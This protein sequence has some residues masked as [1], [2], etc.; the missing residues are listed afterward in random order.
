MSK[1][2]AQ[3]NTAPRFAPY[4]RGE[5]GQYKNVGLLTA[6]ALVIVFFGMPLAFIAALNLGIDSENVFVGIW[7]IT[8]IYVFWLESKV[9]PKVKVGAPHIAALALFLIGVPGILVSSPRNV[10]QISLLLAY[11]F[12]LIARMAIMFIFIP[13]CLTES[14]TSPALIIVRTLLYSSAFVSALTS[15]YFASL[16]FTIFNSIRG[17]P[18]NWLHPNLIS[19]LGSLCIMMTVIDPKLKMP[20]RIFFGSV[21]FYTMLMAQGRTA[22]FS[23]IIV[24]FLIF[25]LELLHDPKK[26][27]PKAALW[28]T[29]L[30]IVLSLATPLILNIPAVQNIQK[31]NEASD[32]LAGR[33]NY[34]AAALDAWRESQIFGYGFRSGV[35]DNFYAVMLLQT[36]IVGLMIYLAFFFMCAIRGYTLFKSRNPQ[37]KLL[38]KTIIILALSFV[39]RSFTEGATILQLTDLPANAFCLAVGLS[40]MIDPKSNKWAD[41]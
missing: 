10:V 37:T 27:A 3:P 14:R 21:G 29:L 5:L 39:I 22:I 41:S 15:I 17:A 32:P 23:T 35:L 19:L 20:S 36:G 26:Y 30:A 40:F 25:M 7:A 31:R 24:L 8:L 11:I 38:G 6:I 12:V 33:E 28:G 4:I 9:R 18:E 2:Q 16:G 1:P 13:R 34:V